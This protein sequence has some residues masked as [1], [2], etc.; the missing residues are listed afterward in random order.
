MP[1][2]KLKKSKRVLKFTKKPTLKLKA[3]PRPSTSNP[4]YT[5]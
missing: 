3:K 5:A 4:R 2:L 1:T